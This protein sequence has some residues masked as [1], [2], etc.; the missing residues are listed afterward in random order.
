ML[1][2]CS[3]AIMMSAKMIF[4]V[5]A[6]LSSFPISH[7]VYGAPCAQRLNVT[8]I[9]ASV[10]QQGAHL[11]ID[12]DLSTL[13][14]ASS[15]S[16]RASSTYPS[17]VILSLDLGSVHDVCTVT[18]AWA[19]GTKMTYSFTIDASTDN[20]QF[21]TVYKGSS[22]LSLDHQPY[23]FSNSIN[24]R[25]IRI[26][27]NDTTSSN[28]AEV[29]VFTSGFN[30][31]GIVVS[32]SQIAYVKSK[33]ASG[34][35]PW[36]AQLAEAKSSSYGSLSYTPHPVAVMQC[37]SFSHPDIGC[38]ASSQDA[39]AAY[40]HALL[41]QFTGD[42]AYAANSIKI[43][44]AWSYTLQHVMTEGSNS[45]NAPLQS[46]WLCQT[47]VKAAEIL[48]HGE[49]GS[50]WEAKDIAK[51]SE[52]INSIFLPLIYHGS[53]ANGNW[54]LS[55]AEATTNI[56]IFT[57]N[58]T[59]F[60]QGL[61]LWRRRVPEYIY[62]TSDGKLPVAPPDR[63][64]TASLIEYWQ[65]QDI[66]V[67]G[68]CQETCRD[69]GHT[70][71]GFAGL[72]HVPETGRLQNIDLWGE[73]RERVFQGFEFHAYF[74]N[75][76][77]ETSPSWLCKG[78][79]VGVKEAG[80]L[81]ELGYNYLVNRLNVPMPNTTVLIERIRTQGPYYDTLDMAWETLTHADVG[82]V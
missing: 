59:T 72:V 10:N 37:G 43:L 64:T 50:G 24:A 81:W 3:F 42:L 48:R 23:A 74:L 79:L 49:G 13:W 19:M 53:G 26:T 22:V 36:T 17:D 44:N 82:S 77:S 57:D 28:V 41:W 8:S 27:F 16:S 4:F 61:V 73:C 25:Y 52:M 39:L 70:Q 69:F 1:L 68:L 78:T 30:H 18:I 29:S 38:S 71:L 67:D 12:G 5:F 66:F 21:T 14:K 54:E 11:A 6:V 76:R 46:A 33:L 15:L 35:Q 65:G 2:C 56:G 75:K 45:S 60:Q 51:F 34:S 55:M 63:K 7:V 31:P 80:Q 47:W 58:S 32:A 40:T 62:L 20:K 9:S